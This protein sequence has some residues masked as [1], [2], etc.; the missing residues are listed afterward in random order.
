[1]G[2]TSCGAG[3]ICFGAGAAGKDD[4]RPQRRQHPLHTRRGVHIGDIHPLA[5]QEETRHRRR[6]E[7]HRQNRPLGRERQPHLF[8]YPRRRPRLRRQHDHEDIARLHLLLERLDPD[9]AAGQPLFVVPH[10]VA[11]RH[12]RRHQLATPGVILGAMAHKQACRW[13]IPPSGGCAPAEPMP[14]AFSP[15]PRSA[16]LYTVGTRRPTYGR[17]GASDHSAL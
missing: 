12:E 16:P 9:S 1:M 8:L 7:H 2:G 15:T 4:R 5:R 6:L 10:V 14:T 11:R 17:S 3:V 13:H